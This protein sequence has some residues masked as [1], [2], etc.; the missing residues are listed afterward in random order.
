MNTRRTS[1]TKVR[2]K[3]RSRMETQLVLLIISQ[4]LKA[5]VCCAAG[6][7]TSIRAVY[8]APPA[9]G[10]DPVTGTATSVFVARPRVF[11]EFM[12]L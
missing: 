11:L 2:R 8:G 10:A 7:G 3:I 5:V 1:I 9:P 12:S 4:M 6:R